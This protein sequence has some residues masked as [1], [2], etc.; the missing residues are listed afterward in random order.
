MSSLCVA[1]QASFI[2]SLYA[3]WEKHSF[4]SIVIF[5]FLLRYALRWFFGITKIRLAQNRY[6]ELLEEHTSLL[7]RQN[8]LLEQHESVLTKLGNKYL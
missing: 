4:I 5:L 7:E 6:T 2:W 1:S 8:Q 3:F